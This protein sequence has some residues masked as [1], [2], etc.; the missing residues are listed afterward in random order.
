MPGASHAEDAALWTSGVR[1]PGTLAALAA[2][3]SSKRLFISSSNRPQGFTCVQN[4]EDNA[5]RSASVRLSAHIEIGED[6]LHQQRVDVDRGRLERAGVPG[7]RLSARDSARARES[8]ARARVSSGVAGLSPGVG[9]GWG[10]DSVRYIRSV[11][12]VVKPSRS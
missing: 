2:R 8:P 6:L 4:S 5:R 10:H 9:G 12:Y 3:S 7:A 1:G 11:S